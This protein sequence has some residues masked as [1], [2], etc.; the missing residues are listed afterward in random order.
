[1]ARRRNVSTRVT[2]ASAAFPLAVFLRAIGGW[3]GTGPIEMSRAL[4]ALERAI[5]ARGVT[6]G[7]AHHF[8]RGAQYL[9]IPQ[10]ARHHDPG[11][12]SHLENIGDACGDALAEAFHGLD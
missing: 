7:R 6:G 2:F 10:S 8:S 12:S 11:F 5:G 4:G 3:R 9:L 1:M